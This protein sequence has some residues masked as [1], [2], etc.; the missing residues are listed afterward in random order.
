MTEKIEV[1]VAVD[2]NIDIRERSYA[3]FEKPRVDKIFG[4]PRDFNLEL[5]Q[6]VEDGDWVTWIGTCNELNASYA[7]DGYAR[8]SGLAALPPRNP[9]WC[10]PWENSTTC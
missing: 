10:A 9:S 7:A 6:R 3:V 4:V 2:W 1:T 8:L 5:V